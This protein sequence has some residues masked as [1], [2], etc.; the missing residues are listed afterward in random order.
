MKKVKTISDFTKY[1][2]LKILDIPLKF[3]NPFKVKK[4]VISHFIKRSFNFSS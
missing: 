1:N 3:K 2:E 4:E